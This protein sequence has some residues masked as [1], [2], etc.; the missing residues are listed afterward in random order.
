[1]GPCD[2]EAIRHF[3]VEV[4]LQDAKT[5]AGRLRMGGRALQALR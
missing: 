3:L 1:M 2:L 4:A 5:R